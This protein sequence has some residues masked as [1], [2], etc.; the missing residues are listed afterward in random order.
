VSLVALGL[1]LTAA[2]LHATWNLLAKQVTSGVPFVWLCAAASTVLWLPVALTAAVLNGV[3]I[4]VAG[5]GLILGS[6][7]IHAGYFVTLQHGYR[8]G[9]LSV[10]YPLARGS[11][12]LAST[13]GAVVVLNERPTPLGIAGLLL[14][15]GGVIGLSY[16]GASLS[17]EARTAARTAAL[18]GLAVGAFIAVYTVWDA[19]TVKVAGVSPVLFIWPSEASR[20]L[21]LAAPAIRQRTDV[22]H[23]WTTH[24]TRIL[25]VAILSPLSYLLILIALRGANVSQVAPLRECSVL[26]GVLLGT[27][28]LGEAHAGRRLLAAAAIFL[29]I[30]A[31]AR[32]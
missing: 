11:A 7:L 8:L 29:G 20:A 15:A 2:V 16:N 28:L 1:V 12:P 24:R 5:L 6:A 32:S 27:R 9:D 14:L 26:I 3:H 13:L 25:L 23:V 31:L 10:T 17:A 21:F 22:R 30:L 19:Y 4:G 18:V